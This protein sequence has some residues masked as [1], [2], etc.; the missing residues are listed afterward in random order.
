[1]RERTIIV[2]SLSK[3]HAMTGWRLG[4]TLGPVSASGHLENLAQCMLFGSPTFIQDAA[5]VTLDNMREP[6]RP[7]RRSI[8]LG[9]LEPFRT[10][11]L[12][13]RSS[14]ACSCGALR[15]LD[16][17]WRGHYATKPISLV[18]ICPQRTGTTLGRVS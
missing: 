12:R 18:E 10:F 13:L 4:W 5:A 8:C 16:P 3:S 6:Y 7:L 1:M 2:N 9:F 17:Q 11:S 14:C 15:C